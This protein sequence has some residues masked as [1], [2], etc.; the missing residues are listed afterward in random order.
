MNKGYCTL[1]TPFLLLYASVRSDDN[2]FSLEWISAKG[3]I[4]KCPLSTTNQFFCCSLNIKL[5]VVCK[6]PFSNTM[7]YNIIIMKGF[8]SICMMHVYAVMQTTAIVVT[9]CN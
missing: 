7:Q 5:I 8:F 3:V 2:A 6:S 9:D 4:R 1:E